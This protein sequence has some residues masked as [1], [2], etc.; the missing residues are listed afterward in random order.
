MRWK[1]RLIGSEIGLKYLS[2]SF[3]DDP[4]IF[5]EEDE[6]YIQCSKFERLSEASE[7]RAAAR[8]LVRTIR[9]FGEKDSIRVE[10]L[11]ASDVHETLDDGTKHIDVQRG[12]DTIQVRSST[13]IAKVYED[14]PKETIFPSADRTYERTQQALEDE[15]VQ[16]LVGIRSRGSSWV[17]LYRIYEYVQDNIGGDRNIVERGWWSNEQKDRFKRTANS[18]EAIGNE[19]RHGT[20]RIPS[21]SEPMS[22][23]RAIYLVD[24]LVENWLRHRKNL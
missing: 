11:E 19:A 9:S 14:G 20:E 23:Y 8:K 21:P 2:K 24:E 4:E 15:K 6:F 7:V 18:R 17:N 16:V 5:A 10:N 12:D 1:V 22:H 3:S 13:R